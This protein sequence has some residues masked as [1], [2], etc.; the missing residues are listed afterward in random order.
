MACCC[1]RSAANAA[2]ISEAR[3]EA[4][5]HRS[6]HD[7]A[8]RRGPHGTPMPLREALGGKVALIVNTASAC[9][10]TPQFAGLQTLQD[11]HEAEGFTVLGVPCNQ[12]FMQE[13]GDDASIASGVCSKFRTTFPVAMKCDVNGDK[14]DPLFKWLKAVAP[15]PSKPGGGTA[16][17]PNFFFAAV[18]RLSNWMAGTKLSEVGRIE[19]NF[20][21]FLVARDG[22][23]VRRYS[24]QTTPEAIEADIVAVLAGR[25][26]EK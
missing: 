4:A 1:A 10:L 13:A 23:V 7:F 20:A 11:R 24:P 26:A 5:R 6:V 17:P 3:A 14:A 16:P 19:H 15:A 22:S 21:K 12:F 25:S 9:G 18:M 8:L 2:E